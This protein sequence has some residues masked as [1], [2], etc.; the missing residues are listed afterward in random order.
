MLILN[1]QVRGSTPIILESVVTKEYKAFFYT[2]IGVVVILSIGFALPPLRP[3]EFTPDVE[4]KAQ[5][6]ARQERAF[7][8]SNLSDTNCACFARKAGHIL[9]NEQPEI[10]GLIYVDS[11]YLARGQA[12]FT[13]KWNRNSE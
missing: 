4:D 11:S 2:I 13:C 10:S 12:S 7:C 8:K 6:L 1:T 9:E 3:R 5:V